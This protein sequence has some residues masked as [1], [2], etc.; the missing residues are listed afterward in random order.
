MTSKLNLPRELRDF[1]ETIRATAKPFI[2]IIPQ[3]TA[4]TSLWESKI[5]GNPYLS[6]NAVYPVD[7]E[8]NQLLFLAQINFEETP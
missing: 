7:L 6:K 8:G 2:K 1:E 5:G 3:N 4:E